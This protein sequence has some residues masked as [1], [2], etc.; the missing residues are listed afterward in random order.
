MGYNWDESISLHNLSNQDFERFALNIIEFEAETHKKVIYKENTGF[1]FLSEFENK[2]SEFRFVFDAIA[3]NGIYDSAF[4]FIEVKKT[5]Q[6]IDRAVN[7]IKKIITRY[8]DISTLRNMSIGNG[9]NS[10]LLIVVSSGN[11]IKEKVL[12]ERNDNLINIW[13]IE[14]L[15]ER[16]KAYPVEYNA[17]LDLVASHFYNSDAIYSI[18]SESKYI[19]DEDF[20]AQ[21][22]RLIAELNK[23]IITNRICLVVGTG[24]SMD[25]NNDLSWN[26]LSNR[27]YE[28]LDYGKRFL[29]EKKAISILGGDNVSSVEYSKRNLGIS[30][31]KTL[32]NLIYPKK[33]AYF[34][35]M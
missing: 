14:D 26:E 3:P 11:A 25:Y 22:D 5:S 13:S 21:N 2:R 4:T 12:D 1:P 18:K 23:S 31:S 33:Q 34:I 17:F 10:K 19:S 32:Y 29:D 35:G 30:Y 8:R 15:I 28:R 6:Q 24:V 27:L 16:A 9:K 7:Q 20:K